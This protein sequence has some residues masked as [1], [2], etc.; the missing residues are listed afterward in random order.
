M[1]S[2]CDKCSAECQDRY[3]LNKM[4]ERGVFAV[5]TECT[6]HKTG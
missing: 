5:V 1:E 2:L 3:D 6:D 4:G